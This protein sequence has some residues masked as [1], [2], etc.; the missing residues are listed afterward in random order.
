MLKCKVSLLFRLTE[1]PVYA[2]LMLQNKEKLDANTARSLQEYKSDKEK[3]RPKPVHKVSTQNRD[4]EIRR[5]DLFK[6]T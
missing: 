5:F 2:I 1:F 4:Y 6:K 3:D